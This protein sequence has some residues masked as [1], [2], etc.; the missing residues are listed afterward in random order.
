MT[1][2]PDVLIVGGG[3]IGLTAAYYLAVDGV[4]VLVLDGANSIGKVW[5]DNRHHSARQRSPRTSFSTSYSKLRAT[6][7]EMYPAHN[8]YRTA[9]MR[10]TGIDNGYVVC[11]GLEIAN[12]TEPL[13]LD[14]WQQKGSRSESLGRWPTA[15]ARTSARRSHRPISLP[16]MAASSQPASRPGLDRRLSAALR[17]L[18]SNRVRGDRLGCARPAALARWKRKRRPPVRWQVPHGRRRRAE[19]TPFTRSQWLSARCAS[20]RVQITLLQAETPLRPILL[21]GK[22]VTLCRQLDGRVLVRLAEEDV[23]FDARPTASGA[24]GPIVGLAVGLGCRTWRMPALHQALLGRSAARQ[25]RWP[26]RS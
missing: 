18:F 25:S 8:H 22:A 1:G 3:V 7:S 9:A 23:G 24:I 19:R 4:T 5:A 2:H 14:A 17:R 6:S 26:C 20:V 11:G 12:E 13:P 10:A 21:H 16:G 15:R